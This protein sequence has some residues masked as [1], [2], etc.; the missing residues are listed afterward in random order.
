MFKPDGSFYTDDDDSRDDESYEIFE[1]CDADDFE[2]MIIEMIGQIS[3]FNQTLGNTISNRTIPPPC[4]IVVII[5]IIIRIIMII[6]MAAV[7]SRLGGRRF[8]MQKSISCN[9]LYSNHHYHHHI[10]Y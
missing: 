7:V 3:L 10:K 4:I 9:I 5:I 8:P 6:A 1:N 2:T